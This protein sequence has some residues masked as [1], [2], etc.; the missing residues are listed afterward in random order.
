MQTPENSSS[1]IL[2]VK[3]TAALCCVSRST[4]LRWRR[5][6]KIRCVKIG[7]RV[8]FNREKVLEDLEQ[9]SV[10]ASESVEAA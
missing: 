6:G 9:F 10:E 7:R 1:S 4:L 2:T 3:E 5:E 8:L